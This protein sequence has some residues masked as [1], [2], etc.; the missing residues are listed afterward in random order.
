L[1]AATAPGKAVLS[2]EYAV[3]SGAPAI[4]VAVNHRVRVSLESVEGELNSLTAP[5]YLEGTWHFG[6]NENRLFN[7]QERLPDAASFAL[8][9]AV[10]N[11]FD[12][13]AWP[14]LSLSID[15]REFCNPVDGKKFGFGSSAAVTVALTAALQRFRSVTAPI[16]QPPLDQAS[17]PQTQLD[18]IAIDSHRR[19]QH[20]RGSGVDIATS[21]KGGLIEYSMDVGSP[22]ACAWPEGLFYR[23]L[24][25]GSSADTPAMLAKLRSIGT[26]KSERS[27][28]ALC[29]AAQ[30]AAVA[31]TG[32][33]GRDVM[34]VLSEYVGV[35]RQ[36]NVDL[37]L[38]IFDA[39]HEQLTDL[40]ADR[41][42]VYKPCGAGGG[43]IGVI[44][45]RS[46]DEIDDFS[47]LATTQGF[48]GLDAEVDEYGVLINSESG[49]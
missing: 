13:A 40:A 9:E 41:D 21:L 6:V 34:R 47:E 37:D 15:T 48:M 27:M 7:W 5:G 49:R 16:D 22:R 39:G 28:Q 26:G 24:W 33:D 35:L 36:F 42:L 20:G 38:S 31:W 2:G 1:I 46:Q 8:V 32:G 19:F 10:W 14:A 11:A 43:D 30:R 44:L 29:N 12:C 23:F 3:L 25:S 17:Q 18:Q 45:A 4:A